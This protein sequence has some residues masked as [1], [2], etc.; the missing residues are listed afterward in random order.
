MKISK[1]VDSAYS[2][3]GVL[4]QRTLLVK[5]AS[6]GHLDLVHLRVNTLNGEGVVCVLTV[7]MP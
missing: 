6:A 5:I 3:S 7:K 2:H 1:N 4:S